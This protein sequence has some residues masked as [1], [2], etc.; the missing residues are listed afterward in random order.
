[1]KMMNRSNF[2][3][4]LMQWV[5]DRSSVAML[6]T[7]CGLV[8]NW[9]PK[10]DAS[11]LRGVVD[12]QYDGNNVEVELASHHFVG[13]AAISS[14]PA[15]SASSAAAPPPVGLHKSMKDS[16]EHLRKVHQHIRVRD[17]HLCR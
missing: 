11:P 10:Y 13:P 16:S 1:M 7:D 3:D 6:L 9:W 5:E 2:S 8:K 17:L 14:S 4:K 15:A 12:S